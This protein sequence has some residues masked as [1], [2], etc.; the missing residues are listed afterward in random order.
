M[1]TRINENDKNDYSATIYTHNTKTKTSEKTDIEIDQSDDTNRTVHIDK[2]INIIN[3][4]QTNMSECR[5][6]LLDQLYRSTLEAIQSI[7]IVL[8]D[9]VSE[10]FRQVIDKYYINCKDIFTKTIDFMMENGF[11]PEKSGAISKVLHWSNIQ[12][13]KIIKKSDSEIAE[14]IISGATLGIID[15][16]RAY[17]NCQCEDSEQPKPLANELIGTLRSFIDELA[18]VL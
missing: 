4:N 5:I 3:K 18:P 10:Q 12:L 14:M 7:E 2:T 6:E 8:K 11:Q 13:N 9:I 15:M 16:Y 1:D 17:N